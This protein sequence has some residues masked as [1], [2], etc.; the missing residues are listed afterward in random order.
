MKLA[1]KLG[2][3]CITAPVVDT[4]PGK[5]GV[6]PDCQVIDRIPDGNKL[7]DEPLP[8]CS[9]G[10]K[11]PGGSCWDLQDDNTCGDSGFKINV[12]RT[13]TAVPGTQQAIKCL[14]CTGKNTAAC[15]H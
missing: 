7:R 12:T 5:P 14:T 8:P 1:A 13:Q 4:N 3:P 9:S 2:N 11:S 15:M 10:N 6:Q